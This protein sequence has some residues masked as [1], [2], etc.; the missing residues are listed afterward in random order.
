MLK[1]IFLHDLQG[2]MITFCAEHNSKYTDR[3]TF[4]IHQFSLNVYKLINFLCKSNDENRS[5]FYLQ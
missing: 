5:Y 2:R 4:S 3:N 1:Q